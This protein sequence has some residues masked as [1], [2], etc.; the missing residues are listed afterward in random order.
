[1]NV[2][3]GDFIQ[4]FFPLAIANISICVYAWLRV[5]Y[6][7]V[8]MLHLYLNESYQPLTILRRKFTNLY[9]NICSR[10]AQVPSF[11]LLDRDIRF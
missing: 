3:Y 1:M 8:Y 11:L 10:I 4:I 9:L 2:C 6:D 7:G 5:Y